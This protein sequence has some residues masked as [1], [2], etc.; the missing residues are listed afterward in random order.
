M[1]IDATYSAYQTELRRSLLQALRARNTYP[2]HKQIFVAL[3]PLWTLIHSF[4]DES[5]AINPTKDLLL[6]YLSSVGD[7]SNFVKISSDHKIERGFGSELKSATKAVAFTSYFNELISD[8]L[9]L[10]NAFHLYN[11]RGS[12]IALRCMTEDLYRHL[13]YKDNHEHFMQVHELGI[14]EHSIK[15]TPM[16]LR[17]YLKSA[18][19]LQPLTNLKWHFNVAGKQYVGFHDLNDALYGRYSAFVHG[20]APSVLNQFA[21]NLDFSYD[22]GRSSE[23]LVLTKQFVILA[24]T[25]LLF[26]HHEYFARFNESTKRLVLNAFDASQRRQIRAL[27][28]A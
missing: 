19:Y 8:S 9:L 11:Y 6:S 28:R 27:A 12:V 3:V 16:D 7:I 4:L 5:I 22:T 10:T 17:K 25:F 26:A 21:S 14:S 2:V 20:A 13:Y 23:I 1:N 18:S 15:I 24:V